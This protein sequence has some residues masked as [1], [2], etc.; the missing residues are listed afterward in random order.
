M[1]AHVHPTLAA[2]LGS[3]APQPNPLGTLLYRGWWHTD[4][5]Q[6]DLYGE[7]PDEDHGCW[8]QAVCVHGTAPTV[9]N[10]IIE[11][12]ADVQLEKMG[13]WLDLKDNPMTKHAAERS[14]CEAMRTRFASSGAY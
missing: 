14:R 12:L 4:T 5:L 2:I 1:N 11:L 8:V 3:I 7:L 6:L 9:A 10:N 13:E